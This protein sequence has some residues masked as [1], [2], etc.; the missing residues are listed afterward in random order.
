MII[1]KNTCN[2]TLYGL[3][4]PKLKKKNGQTTLWRLEYKKDATQNSYLKAVI[5][6]TRNVLWMTDQP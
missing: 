6:V 1:Y 2:L 5:Q 3:H 4:I